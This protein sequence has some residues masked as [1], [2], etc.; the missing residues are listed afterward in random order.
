MN[1]TIRGDIER[2]L[3]IPNYKFVSIVYDNEV[4]RLKVSISA[5]INNSNQIL[6]AS[7]KSTANVAEALN[8]QYTILCSTINHKRII[9]QIYGS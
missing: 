4:K 5:H 3:S 7:E 9:H 1:A 6:Y 8:N 2:L